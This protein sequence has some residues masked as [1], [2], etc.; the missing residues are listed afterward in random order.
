VILLSLIAVS[1][2]TAFAPWMAS[3][4][5]TVERR[6]PAL[7]ATGLAVWGLVIRLVIAVS[8][9]FVP[10]VVTTV[11]PLVE[12]GPVVQ[13]VLASTTPVGQTT[14]GKVATA[15]AAHPDVIARLQ[16]LS[17]PLTASDKAFVSTTAPQ[18]LGAAEFAALSK[19]TPA[20]SHALETLGTVGPEVKQAA[21]ESPK[22]WRTY[23]FIGVAGEVV[24]VPLI[25][26]MA[27]YWSPRR[28]KRAEEEHEAM[29]AAE[30]AKLRAA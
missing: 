8:V 11:T 5:E 23:F 26:V 28:A 29:I 12:K 24:F 27:G 16:H 18:A 13:E 2:G 6:N 10:K 1:L 22:Q 9:F 7:I 14:V 4:T 20:L 15:A 21:A 3:F 25:L 19:P 30:M 17:N